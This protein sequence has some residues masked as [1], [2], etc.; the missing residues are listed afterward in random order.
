MVCIRLPKNHNGIDGWGDARG[1]MLAHRLYLKISI[2]C[3]GSMISLVN[4]LIKFGQNVL[5]EYVYF[6]PLN[7]ETL[8]FS[9][10]VPILIKTAVKFRKKIEKFK[11]MIIF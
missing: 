5:T 3:R 8:T 4:L 6:I 2:M 9:S 10:I 1:V 11:G 7:V